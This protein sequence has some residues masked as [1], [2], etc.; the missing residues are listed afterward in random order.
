MKQIF[1]PTS[2]PPWNAQICALFWSWYITRNRSPLSAVLRSFY[3]LVSYLNSLVSCLER[4]VDATDIHCDNPQMI[5]KKFL[6]R[7]L[8]FL[9][10]VYTHR[11]AH[12]ECIPL[13]CFSWAWVTQLYQY[14]SVQNLLVLIPS[15]S[16]E[17]TIR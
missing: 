10:G 1:L 4:I 3:N 7:G 11:Y 9:R 8:I 2:L 13:Q 12:V 14:S 15:L 5:H 17:Q 16:T 6:C